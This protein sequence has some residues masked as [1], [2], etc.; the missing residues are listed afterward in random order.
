MAKGAIFF[1]LI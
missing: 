1:A